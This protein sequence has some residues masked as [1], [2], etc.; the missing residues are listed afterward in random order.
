[1][2]LVIT[3]IGVVV[4]GTLKAH[5]GG[6]G[7]AVARLRRPGGQFWA[8]SP[9]GAPWAITGRGKTVSALCTR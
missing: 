6:K 4:D 3:R 7:L 1:M 5:R 8:A 9:S 2:G